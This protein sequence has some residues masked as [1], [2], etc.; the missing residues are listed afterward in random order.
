[1]TLRA[2]HA[3]GIA[4][5]AASLLL[6]S[7]ALGGCPE[8][9]RKVNES[10]ASDSECETGL[11]YGT[12]LVSWEDNDAD[13]LVNAVERELGSDPLNADTDGD[14]S[15]DGAE[16]AASPLADLLDADGDEVADVL[17]SLVTDT[18]GDCVVDQLD[19]ANDTPGDSIDLMRELACPPN[20][21]VCTDVTLG[22]DGQQ[23]TCT[24]NSPDYEAGGETLCDGLDNDCDGL[25]DEDVC[26]PPGAPGNLA[27]AGAGNTLTPTVSGTT[28]AD[29]TVEVF[30]DAA[31]AGARVGL[32]LVLAD[33]TFSA[34]VS[35]QA[36]STT[37]FFVHAVS[38]AGLASNCVEAGSYTHDGL[39]PADP[40][41]TNS[42]PASPSNST[43][44]SLNG[45]TE[46]SASL[47]FFFGTGCDGLPVFATD[48]AGDGSY[49]AILDVPDNATT[50][51]WARATDAAGN[52]SACVELLTFTH[53]DEA[54]AAPTG[55]SLAPGTLLTSTALQ[56]AG[57]LSE[58]A[59][60]A[61]FIGA[62]CTGAA[63]VTEAVSGGSFDL[64]LTL[65]GDGDFAISAHAVD[66]AGNISACASAGTVTVDTQAPAAPVFT[67]HS[68]TGFDSGDVSTVSATVEGVAEPGATVAL[69]GNDCA[70]TELAT[71]IADDSGAFAVNLTV[72]AQVEIAIVATATDPAGNPSSCSTVGEELVGIVTGTVPPDSQAIGTWVLFNNPDG[73]LVELMLSEGDP[74]ARVM[75]TGSYLSVLQDSDGQVSVR[76]MVDVK[77]GDTIDF[78]ALPGGFLGNEPSFFP[79]NLPALPAGLETAQTYVTQGGSDPQS[80]QGVYTALAMDPDALLGFLGL[81]VDANNAPVAYSFGETTLNL[82]GTSYALPDWQLLG[83]PDLTVNINDLPSFA[84]DASIGLVS[85]R[86]G[87]FFPHVGL[88]PQGLNNAIGVHLLDLGGTTDTTVQVLVD[89]ALGLGLWNGPVTAADD[90]LVISYDTDFLPPLS[91]PVS[92]G[93]EFI[94][95][96]VPGADVIRVNAESFGQTYV[97]WRM[98]LPPEGGAYKI[99]ELPGAFSWTMPNGNLGPISAVAIDRDSVEGYD[100]H[101]TQPQPFELVGQPDETLRVSSSPSMQ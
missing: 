49:T 16:V 57:G 4:P 85:W 58:D 21:G 20:Q 41:L 47:L 13:G 81:A 31:C 89:T 12:C 79:V 97:E 5:I 29:T 61:I 43:A 90:G 8:E 35:V 22:C 38:A 30:T 50:V 94:L 78:E 84:N 66:A 7:L 53:D 54:P 25:V 55:L 64:A 63:E 2:P 80:A 98:I 27:V 52:T 73:S 39:P 62:D 3:V 24:V 88:P 32:G 15:D 72:D 6:A 74:R 51:V 59:D 65:P 46:A 36:E 45:S 86:N 10:C 95:Q 56:V 40:T 42:L 71:V 9:R 93:G 60:I 83:A 17:E 44:L 91:V 26:S 99:P 92:A 19:P 37:T 1:M 14:G 76:T 87:Q 70:T 11:C 75:P 34:T 23:A 101:R 77:P 18:D 48:A 82:A 69:F 33:G 68:P 67:G 100:E 28:D 96:A